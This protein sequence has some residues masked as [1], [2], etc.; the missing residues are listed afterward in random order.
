VTGRLVRDLS[1]NLILGIVNNK[2][3]LDWYGD[4]SSGRKVPAGV[5]FVRLEAEGYARVEKV[6]FLR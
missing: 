2:S 5:Y 4:D 1:Q 6:I 3:S